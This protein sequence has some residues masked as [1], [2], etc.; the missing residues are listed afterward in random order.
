M[1][2]PLIVFF[3][4]SLI[5]DLLLIFIVFILINYADLP[6]FLLICSPTNLMPLP[7]YGSGFLKD[8]ILLQQ[9]LTIACHEKITLL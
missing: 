6:A 2:S 5:F 3:N 9:S 1:L 7:L 4:L 8:L